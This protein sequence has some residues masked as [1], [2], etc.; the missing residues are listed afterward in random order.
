MKP[1]IAWRAPTDSGFEFESVGLDR[2]E[3]VHVDGFALVRL[4]ARGITHLTSLGGQAA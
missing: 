2:R 1:V 4:S 3:C